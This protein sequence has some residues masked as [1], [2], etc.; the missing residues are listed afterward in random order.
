LEIGADADEPRCM[1]PSV[2]F[3]GRV[4][5]ELEDGVWGDRPIV[6]RG[7]GKRPESAVW[8]DRR[9][10][11]T[12]CCWPQRGGDLGAGREWQ[13]GSAPGDPQPALWVGPAD[14]QRLRVFGR[15]DHASDDSFGGE[16]SSDL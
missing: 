10:G 11:V 7:A 2:M 6:D 12:G 9:P 13:Q 4:H 8:D 1:A 16:P 15:A 3:E 5:V 14:D